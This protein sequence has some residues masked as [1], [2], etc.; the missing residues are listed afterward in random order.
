MSEWSIDLGPS[1]S[2]QGYR[3]DTVWRHNDLVVT[4]AAGK[5]NRVVEVNLMALYCRRMELRGTPRG[6]EERG[7]GPGESVQR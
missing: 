5:E 6:E 1:C 4:K 7:R 3:N 2:F